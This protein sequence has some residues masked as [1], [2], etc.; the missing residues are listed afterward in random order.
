MAGLTTAVD[1]AVDDDGNIFV[2]EMTSIWSSA[3]MPRDFDL[4]DPDAASGPG[5]PNPSSD[6]VSSR[7]LR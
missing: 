2:V 5:G 7:F 3:K 6:A 4:F 1:V